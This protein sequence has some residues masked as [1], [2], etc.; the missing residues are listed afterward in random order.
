MNSNAKAKNITTCQQG[1]LQGIVEEDV[2]AFYDIPYGENRGRF[3]PVDEPLGWQGVRD[4]TK[5]GPVFSQLRSRL[6]SV[7]GTTPEEL[8]QSED[9]FRLNIWTSDTSAK[10]PV[11]FWI[12][13]G[14]FMTGGG[15]LRWYHGHQL[16]ASGKMIVVTVNYRL[17]ALGNLYLPG[18][19]E[20]NLALQD[21]LAALHWVQN[22]IAAFGGD[23][24]A[25]TIAGQSAGAWYSTVL[26]ACKQAE[27]LFKQACLLSHPGSVQPLPQE[28]ARSLAEKLCNKLEIESSGEQLANIPID[29]LLAA[30]IE[31][32][33][34]IALLYEVTLSFIP[35]NDGVFLHVAM[36]MT[37]KQVHAEIRKHSLLSSLESNS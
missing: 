31:V 34:E 10:L 13:G 15:A 18:V 17:G 36:Y 28:R 33:K 22:N 23:P 3:Q 37:P 12:H 19:S 4:A 6:A 32:A 30:E 8:N 21:L 24:S 7:N 16:A 25:I 5:P 1:D 11:L 27:G 35:I 14:G 2:L 29:Q 20:G 9:A 26:M